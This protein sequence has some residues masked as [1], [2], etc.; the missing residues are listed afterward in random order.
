M[1]QGV[2][3][4]SIASGAAVSGDVDLRGG[5]LHVIA[6]PAL[7]SG[8]LFLHGSFDTTSANFRKIQYPLLNGPTS[9]DMRLATG[10]GSCVILRLETSV[11]QAAPRVFSVRFGN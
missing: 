7:T 5:R 6:C 4:V 11:A 9:G 1:R 8:D 2:L 3:D 10:P